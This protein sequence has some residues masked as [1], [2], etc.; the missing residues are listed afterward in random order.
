M[1]LVETGMPEILT[2]R[3]KQGIH[4]QPRLEFPHGGGGKMLK[5]N[6]DY[7]FLVQLAHGSLTSLAHHARS[8]KDVC[9]S[10]Y[11]EL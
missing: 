2:S 10:Q 1:D 11:F 5:R 8:R 9:Y 6:N 4:L 7:I 3:Q